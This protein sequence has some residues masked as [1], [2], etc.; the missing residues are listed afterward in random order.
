MAHVKNNLITKGIS[1]MLGDTLVFKQVGK[2]TIV[3][4][5]PQQPAELSDKQ[6]A[7]RLR[8][9]QAAL[10][11]KG[12]LADP[13]SKAEY[14]KVAKADGDVFTTAYNVAVADFLSA[15]DIEEIDV[16]QYTGAVGSKIRVTVADD[17]KVKDV[18][19]T[20]ANPDGSLVE[21]GPAVQQANLNEWLYTAT[22]QNDTLAGD[23]ITITAHDK[24]GNEDVEVKEL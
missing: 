7:V 24:P 3:S 16:S 8:F 10:Y 23:K 13:A 11:A 18:T 6:K 9:Q 5:K 17:F 2:E 21:S 4:T 12:Q 22:V 19:V 20:I 1:G 14:E 15:P